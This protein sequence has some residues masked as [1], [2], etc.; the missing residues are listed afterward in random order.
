[1][2]ILCV[3]L[4]TDMIPAISMAWETAESDIMKRPP[5]NA[6]IDRLVTKKLI[7]FAYLQIGVIQALAGF[8]TFFVV[9]MDYGYPAYIL[10]DG[11]LGANDDW[12]KQPLYC[13][14]VDVPTNGKMWADEWGN[15]ANEYGACT[16]G[17]RDQGSDRG[18]KLA[19]CPVN[20]GT[21]S[22]DCKAIFFTTKY[23]ARPGSCYFAAK[24]LRN[25]VGSSSNI[26][27]PA[28]RHPGFA[29]DN[30]DWWKTASN[31]VEKPETNTNAAPSPAFHGASLAP[32]WTLQTRM[33]L[34]MNGYYEYLP[35][36]G[37]LSSFYDNAWLQARPLD[38]SSTVPGLGGLSKVS[39]P[40]GASDSTIMFSV[41]PVGHW[42]MREDSTGAFWDGAGAGAGTTSVY[43]VD[44]VKKLLTDASSEKNWVAVDSNKKKIPGMDKPIKYA[45]LVWEDHTDMRETT[46][47]DLSINSGLSKNA[48]GVDVHVGCQHKPYMKYDA[49]NPEAME[50]NVA[51]RMMQK[52]A[53][54]HAQS[55]YF[56]CIVIVQWADLVISKTR[57]NSMFQQGMSNPLM[58]FGLIAETILAAFLCY[59]PGVNTALGTRPLRF[60]HWLPGVPFSM[61]IFLC[62]LGPGCFLFRPVVPSCWCCPAVV[63]PPLIR[64]ALTSTSSP[65]SSPLQTGTTRLASS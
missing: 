11:H 32:Q 61:F 16:G 17:P 50:I 20:T 45:S 4:G 49:N 36:K 37:R 56:V 22:V 53:L 2:L 12:G 21:C 30:F 27:L 52:E 5:R 64:C 9:L 15:V 19:D 65:L 51:S 7:M 59:T 8:Y 25:E 35:Y 55:A 38:S 26:F 57:R 43:G 24:N 13:K 14:P 54:H 3:D 62:V 10:F 63:L 41:Q 44:D 42:T 48:L 34:T 60:T 6:D 31:Y 28:A 46:C 23:G 39:I 58:N 1:M 18:G 47:T 29:T 33:S 40:Q